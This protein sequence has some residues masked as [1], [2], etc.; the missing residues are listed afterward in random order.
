MLS[1]IES[2]NN[3]LQTITNDLSNWQPGSAGQFR[4]PLGQL[5]TRSNDQ[6]LTRLIAEKN[7]LLSLPGYS[8]YHFEVTALQKRIEKLQDG[9]SASGNAASFQVPDG[10]SAATI[11]NQFVSGKSSSR[12]TADKKDDTAVAKVVRE[13]ASLDLGSTVRELGALSQEIVESRNNTEML[14]RRMAERAEGKVTAVSPIV[15]QDFRKATVSIPVGGTPTGKSF[16]WLALIAGILGTVVALN[17]DPTLNIRRFRSLEHLQNCLGIPV[18]GSVRSRIAMQAP[19]SATRRMAAV[20]VR[21]GEWT[22]LIAIVLLLVAAFS[23]VKS[24]THFQKTRFMEL[25]EPFG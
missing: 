1:R 4:S 15:V 24:R 21:A 5:D 16:M 8:P 6:E 23:T 22:L 19:R 12:D 10:A 20:A 25:H 11:R 7:R 3:E 2:A 9:T 14:T 18:V 17:Y 13:I